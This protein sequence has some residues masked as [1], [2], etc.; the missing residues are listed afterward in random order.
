MRS[1]LK[2]VRRSKN[3]TQKKDQKKDKK[4]TTKKR[5]P[6]FS[7]TK[8]RH[9]L[10]LVEKFM[11]VLFFYPHVYGAFKLKSVPLGCPVL[12]Q[13][14]FIP[15]KEGVA[16]GR[17]TLLTIVQK[18]GI[19]LKSRI[20]TFWM[21]V[22][23]VDRPLVTT[24]KSGFHLAVDSLSRKT[25]KVRNLWVSCSLFLFSSC[26]LGCPVLLLSGLPS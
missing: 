19:H 7:R 10:F 20:P 16:K 25:K 1:A 26:S 11:G 9:P 8:K 23:G 3:G 17:I 4:R 14:L 18:V 24:S 12:L 13:P 21:T 22:S 6:T 15:A 2:T 5:T